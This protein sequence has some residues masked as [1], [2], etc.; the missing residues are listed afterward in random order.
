[1]VDLV[2]TVSDLTYDATQ[3]DQSSWIKIRNSYQ[4]DLNILMGRY[5]IFWFLEWFSKI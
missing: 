1:M 4:Q 5:I 3:T 2:K